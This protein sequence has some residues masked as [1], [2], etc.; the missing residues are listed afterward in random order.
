[1]KSL[2]V[3]TLFSIIFLGFVGHEQVFADHTEVTITP[4]QGSGAPGCEDTAKDAF[5]QASYELM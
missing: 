5:C 1:M 2:L 3:L 4:A